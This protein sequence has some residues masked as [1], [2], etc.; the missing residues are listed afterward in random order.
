[1]SAVVA[2][3]LASCGLT[4]ALGDDDAGEQTAVVGVLVPDDGPQAADGEGV[5]AAVDLALDET[6]SDL[7]G[8]TVETVPIAEGDDQAAIADDVTELIEGDAVAIVGGLTT[9][10]VRA[11]QPV[12]DAEQVLFV[13]PADVDVTHTRGA[14]VENPLRP[15]PTYFRTA[16]TDES[17]AEALVRHARTS[18]QAEKL[19]VVDGGDPAETGAFM[20]A[21]GDDGPAVAGSAGD[22]AAVGDLVGRMESSSVEAVFVAGSPNVAGALAEQISGAGLDITV[23]GT[24]AVNDDAYTA[25]DHGDGTVTAQ[26]PELEPTAGYRP[27]SL[28]AELGDAG[29]GEYGAAAYDAA[30]AIGTVLSRCLPPSSTA[31]DA[32]EGCAGEMMQIEFAGVTGDVAFDEFGDRA[33][34]V[35]ELEVLREGRWEPLAGAG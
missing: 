34:G 33:G 10:A 2:A 31:V 26:P 30:T 22:A 16:V 25:G 24:S 1:M 8:W 6:T 13:S 9:P 14:D 4:D 27:D 35:V 12:T 5:Q 23:L 18:L 29:L 32:R 19:A 21:I 11:V 7:T 15:Y 3:L 17:A 20:D 28:D